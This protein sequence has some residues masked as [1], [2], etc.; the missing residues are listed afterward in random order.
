MKKIMTFINEHKIET[1]AIVTVICALVFG[2]FAIYSSIKNIEEAGGFRQVIVESGK[3][4]K[5][6]SEDINR[7]YE[8]EKNN[9]YR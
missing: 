8:K 5:L 3:E 7:A 6:L 1:G 2:F 9:P 4:I